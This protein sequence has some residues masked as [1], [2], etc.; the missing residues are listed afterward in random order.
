MALQACARNSLLNGKHEFLR[1]HYVQESPVETFSINII[2][3]WPHI[4]PN[5]TVIFS[6]TESKAEALT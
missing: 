3:S 4:K 5:A 1:F 6:H 2:G